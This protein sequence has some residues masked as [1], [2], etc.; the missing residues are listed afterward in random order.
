MAPPMEPN[1]LQTLY[2]KSKVKPQNWYLQF[3]VDLSQKIQKTIESQNLTIEDLEIAI[4]QNIDF[5]NLC[6][7][8]FAKICCA[9]GLSLDEAIPIDISLEE[10]KR[11]NKWVDKNFSKELKRDDKLTNFAIRMA[12]VNLLG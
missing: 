11:W 10:R 2:S 6:Q 9:I 3:Q 5:S 7:G 1:V 8:Q 12:A 4:D